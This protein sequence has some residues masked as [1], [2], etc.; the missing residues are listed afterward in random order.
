LP[1]T[2]HVKFPEFVDDWLQRRR[3]TRQSIQLDGESRRQLLDRAKTKG[4]KD[5]EFERLQVDYADAYEKIWNPIRAKQ[6]ARLA[7][8]AHALGV[9]VQSKPT[10]YGENEDW[11]FSYVTGD[12][13][14]KDDAKARIKREIKIE[15][16]QTDDEFRKWA[17]LGL[18]IA[19]FILA[20]V[21]L[22]V[23]QKRPDP[24]PAN[25]YRSDS[26]ECVFAIQ[27]PSRLRDQ[28]QQDAGAGQKPSPPPTPPPP[29]STKPKP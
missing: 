25:Y 10:G 27:N 15:K 21:S 11:G 23:K 22:L 29:N 14:L 1:Y 5:G 18:S 9:R 8:R 26:G 6:D 12:F 28:S 3:A 17:T 4:L 13:F 20:L 7:A 24:C 2:Q 19:A 16:R